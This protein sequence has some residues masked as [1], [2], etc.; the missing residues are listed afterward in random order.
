VAVG[1]IVLAVALLA[2]L[3]WA[4]GGDGGSAG[5]GSGLGGR[6]VEAVLRGELVSETGAV[7]AVQDPPASYHVVYASESYLDGETT[8]FTE[9]LTVRRPFEGRVVGLSGAPPGGQVEYELVSELGLVADV[10]DPDDTIVL[11]QPPTLAAGDVRLDASLA[12]LVD[13]GLFQVRE[14]RRVLGR[15]CTVYRSGASP[16]SEVLAAPTAEEHTDVC[17]DDAGLVLEELSVLDGEV[18]RRSIATAVELGPSLAEGTFRVE[19]EPLPGEEGGYAVTPL[20]AAAPPGSW[21]FAVEPE[22]FALQGRYA[23]REFSGDSD[24]AVETT[25]DVW[26]RGVDALFLEQGPGEGDDPA[27]VA[28][29]AISSVEGLGEVVTWPGATGNVLLARPDDGGFLQLSGSLPLADLL[30]LA[31]T[32][33]RA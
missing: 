7:V 18:V 26:V 2:G 32:L 20:D 14:R 29:A 23:V 17:V 3:V 5:G 4:G 13:R 19:G 12:D 11:Q 1:A 16:D 33:T 31:A 30:A 10:T 27:G 15:E 22:G 28:G 21:R 9:D 6:G 24:D 8:A 25:V